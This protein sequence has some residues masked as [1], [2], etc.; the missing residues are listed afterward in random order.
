M[1]RTNLLKID[2][3]K[4]AEIIDYLNKNKKAYA[5]IEIL[6][7]A[8]NNV[9]LVKKDN[10]LKY[11][12]TNKE[13]YP[14]I[15]K[16]I[17][18]DINKSSSLILKSLL[19]I[20]NDKQ[21]NAILVEELYIVG[22]KIKIDEQGKS[23]ISLSMKEAI[24]HYMKIAKYHYQNIYE[25]M[26]KMRGAHKISQTINI[27][28]LDG[29]ID[30]LEKVFTVYKE[31][32]PLTVKGHLSEIIKKIKNKAEKKETLEAM[33]Y[34]SKQ[35]DSIFKNL[36][37][38]VNLS[39][40]KFINKKSLIY[41]IDFKGTELEVLSEDSGTIRK[42][43]STV[44]RKFKGDYSIDFYLKK[45][46]LEHL[47]QRPIL[48]VMSTIKDYLGRDKYKLEVEAGTDYYNED[49]PVII[50][51]DAQLKFINSMTALVSAKY[52]AK[53]IVMSFPNE[54]HTGIDWAK[55]LQHTRILD[56]FA[57]DNTTM[58]TSAN[59]LK[60]IDDAARMMSVKVY[61]RSV[62]KDGDL[63]IKTAE[64]EY[65]IQIIIQRI[66]NTAYKDE[67]VK[68]KNDIQHL[69]GYHDRATFHTTLKDSIVVDFRKDKA[70]RASKEAIELMKKD[71]RF[72][73]VIA[74]MQKHPYHNYFELDKDIF[75]KN[76]EFDMRELFYF[77]KNS[78]KISPSVEYRSA[79]KFRKLGNYNALGIYFTHTK[80]M[81]IDYRKGRESYV[82]ELS[83][84]IDL[85]G[86][87]KE[88]KKMIAILYNY[89]KRRVKSRA[90]YFLRDE[91]LIA[92]AAEVAL[93]LKI[94]K[95]QELKQMANKHQ[96]LNEMR[97]YYEESSESAFMPKWEKFHSNEPYIDIQKHIQEGSLQILDTVYD[98]FSSYWDPQAEEVTIPEDM[99]VD[100]NTNR[101]KR[102]A[103]THYSYDYYMCEIYK[104]VHPKVDVLRYIKSAYGV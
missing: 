78:A 44:Y 49:H 10:I 22:H 71:E 15:L 102:Y 60:A 54:V 85:N 43:G 64:E 77:L 1:S 42:K 25:F 90:D 5:A 75:S 56:G 99:E 26:K 37:Y 96:A 50:Q 79:L 98:Y 95:Y 86:F 81:G 59:M 46:I 3:L 12:N 97:L 34:I 16:D 4:K 29:G 82:H 18:G 87:K 80:T 88:R 8:E 69:S 58:L 72:K 41:Y 57:L 55:K 51:C 45:K 23:F 66:L 11:Q 104:I 36:Y 65:Y 89:F 20:Y 103:S 47:T 7:Y 53:R 35:D 84:H 24:E 33:E 67:V 39:E 28:E 13:N 6:L 74:V 76:S 32:H 9:L 101:N 94:S 73:K 30:F 62:K 52:E 27:D 21:L 61:E 68:N 63:F 93:A 17:I 2:L 19:Q 38:S 31:V 91:E 40:E 100:Y 48:E 14:L 83:H 92:R 70:G